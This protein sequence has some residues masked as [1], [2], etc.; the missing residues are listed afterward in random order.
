MLTLARFSGFLSS[1]F[2]RDKKWDKDGPLIVAGDHTQ[3]TK[4][5]LT[6][7]PMPSPAAG[8]ALRSSCGS[9]G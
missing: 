3:L 2:S 4:L 8:P 1:L 7:P 6:P 5:P 9:G